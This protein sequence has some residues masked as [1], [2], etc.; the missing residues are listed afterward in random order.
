MKRFSVNLRAAMLV[1]AMG[2]ALAT[3]QEESKAGRP[4]IGRPDDSAVEAN[5]ERQAVPGPLVFGTNYKTLASSTFQPWIGGDYTGSFGTIQSA[6]AGGASYFRAPLDLPHGATV[7]SVEVYIVDNDPVNVANA[8]FFQD[9]TA[10]GTYTFLGNPVVTGNTGETP[11]S[12]TFV[13][14]VAGGA[15][16]LDTSAREYSVVI[17]VPGGDPDFE[18]LGARVGY[19]GPL[20]TFIAFAAPD[21]FVDTRDGRGGKNTKYVNGESFD[22]TITGVAGLDLNIIPAGAKGILGNVVAVTPTQNGLFKI[23]PGGTATTLGRASVNFN[24][25]FNT[26]NAITVR[27]DELGRIR[28]F[29]NSPG[30]TTDLVVDVVGYYR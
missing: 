11:G 13:V 18:I 1:F 3:A 22:H 26:G 7:T 30:G 21:R 8:W 15:Q 14:P 16:V 9:N 27:L 25:G 28:G 2:G 19:T 20:G 17:H 6:P 29:H 24:G 23:L 12:R 5:E 4:M 10:D